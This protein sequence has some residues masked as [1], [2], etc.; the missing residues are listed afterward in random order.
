MLE[1]AEK[2]EADA[3]AEAS[4]AAADEA[5]AAHYVEVQLLKAK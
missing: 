5:D 3:I 1:D 4:K 2:A